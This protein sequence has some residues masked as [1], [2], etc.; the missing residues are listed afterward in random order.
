MPGRNGQSAKRFVHICERLLVVTPDLLRKSAPQGVSKETYVFREVHPAP[1]TVTSGEIFLSRNE[2]IPSTTKIH[3]ITGTLRQ[4]SVQHLPW[5]CVIF[6]LRSNSERLH[7]GIER[8][9]CKPVEASIFGRSR[10]G[11]RGSTHDTKHGAE[12]ETN[13]TSVISIEPRWRKV[14]FK[15]IIKELCALSSSAAYNTLKSFNI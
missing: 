13:R 3:L 9:Q 4:V 5:R 6:D 12:A 1:W 7:Y 14:T 8:L 11:H 15:N 10:L 2:Q